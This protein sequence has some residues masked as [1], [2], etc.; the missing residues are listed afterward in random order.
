MT[1][2]IVVCSLFD[3]CSGT[4][5][6]LKN[7][8]IPVYKYY[9]SEIDKYAIQITRKN[10]PNTI[11]LGDVKEIK[12]EDFI[13]DIDLLTAGSPCQGFS[14]AGKRLAFED[15]RSVLFFEFIRLLEELKPKYF[16]LENVKMKKEHQ[17]VINNAIGKIYPECVSGSL[18]G[19]EPIEINSSLVSAQ[20]RKRL[21]WTNIPLK[22]EQP[23][24]LGI[25]LKDILETHPDP[26]H[27]ISDQKKDRVLNTKRGKGRFY[28]AKDEKIGTVIA[29][30][31]KEPTDAPY[32]ETY[33]TPKQVAVAADVNGHDSLKR[34]YS[35]VG[36][37]PTVNAHGG[38]NT[39]PKVAVNL[40]NK[41]PISKLSVKKYVPN[42]DAEFVDPYNKKTITGDKS[43][44]L[45]TNSS[46]GN[47]WVNDKEVSWRK[48]TPLECER[49]Q[50]LPD[51]YTEGVSNTQRY[52]MI[53]NG[54][55]IKVIEHFFE[56]IM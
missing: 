37:S 39:E 38:G 22:Q 31:H 33:K 13:H 21:Y 47:M 32:L 3:G 16:L 34:I 29:G 50:T 54:F 15:E 25:V 43:T 46:N 2:G 40:G 26:K 5:I 1:K 19:I 12:G 20:N 11:H 53:G 51:N 27:E 24:D 9:A 35:E 10:F 14:F 45:R 52:K 55:T 18:F 7:L 8:G 17:E 41:I 49:L 4:Q 28:T 36:K 56:N 48:L 44:T 6:A 42:P 30:Y 23:D